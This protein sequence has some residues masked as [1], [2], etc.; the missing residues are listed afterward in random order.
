MNLK[1][2]DLKEEALTELGKKREQFSELA[3]LLWHSNGTIAL[4]ID[5]IVSVYS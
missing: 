2:P 4:L 5:D 3:P 1:D